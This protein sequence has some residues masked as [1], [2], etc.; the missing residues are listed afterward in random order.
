MQV[1]KEEF[2]AAVINA[3]IGIPR[4]IIPGLRFAFER[5]IGINE[6][7]SERYR[8]K[9]MNSTLRHYAWQARVTTRF[10][11]YGARIPRVALSEFQ[12]CLLCITDDR[13][14]PT[15]AISIH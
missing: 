9:S 11:V 10:G 1:A 13:L 3:T 14:D 4:W 2:A 6:T 8:W 12:S 5:A 7:L 15:T